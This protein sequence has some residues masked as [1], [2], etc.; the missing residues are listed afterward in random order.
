MGMAA[1][2]KIDSNNRAFWALLA[3]RLCKCLNVQLFYENQYGIKVLNRK[4]EKAPTVEQKLI[5]DP[6]LALF[7]ADGLKDQ[8]TLTNK[9]IINS[10]HF[11]FIKGILENDFSLCADYCE[12]ESHGMLDGRFPLKLNKTTAEMHINST[13]L[14]KKL[15]K[16]GSYAR[17]KV[18]FFDGRYYA[19]DGKHRLSM[20]AYLGMNIECDIVSVSDI[21]SSQYIIS[22]YKKM[23]LSPKN[24]SNNLGLLSAMIKSVSY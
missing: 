19:I 24:Y 8:Y 14:N 9:T 7:F 17:P 5:I 10:P 2:Y 23:S 12:R 1:F 22:I 21:L 6:S 15:L 13:L 4:N 16:K 20:A 3:H 18:T 11:F